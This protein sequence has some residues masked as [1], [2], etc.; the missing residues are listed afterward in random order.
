[1]CADNEVE[2]GKDAEAEED[3]TVRTKA[4]VKGWLLSDALMFT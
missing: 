1:M 2:T 3:V 4:G